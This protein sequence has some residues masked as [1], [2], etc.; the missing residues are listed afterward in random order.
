MVNEKFCLWVSGEPTSVTSSIARALDLALAGSGGT[1][2]LATERAS[3][4][5]DGHPRV[6][7]VLV[8]DTAGAPSDSAALAA[9]DVVVPGDGA[10]AGE[11]A[12]L[13]LRYLATAGYSE[14]LDEYSDDDEAAV[15]VRLQAFGY[16]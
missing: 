6:V 16:L 1:V 5:R 14:P 13:V 10:R 15:S 4:S 8:G 9:P 3:A 2:V 11:S 7:E 12:R